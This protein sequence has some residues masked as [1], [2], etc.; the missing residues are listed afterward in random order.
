MTKKEVNKTPL[1]YYCDS[2]CNIN[3]SVFDY[4]INI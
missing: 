3:I 4:N 2:Y 1:V